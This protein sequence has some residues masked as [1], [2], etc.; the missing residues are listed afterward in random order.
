MSDALT[1]VRD[2]P[3]LESRPQGWDDQRY[4]AHW[5][6]AGPAVRDRFGTVMTF[7]QAA[8]A[9][10]TDPRITRQAGVE[11]LWVQGIRSGP[12]HE[13]FENSVL[14]ANGERHK[15][16]RGPLARA[17]AQPL[18][19]AL[20]GRVAEETEALVR[21]LL[22]RGEADFPA[23][24][25]GP[26]PARMIAAILGAPEADIPHFT[27][28]VYSAS[29]ALS[30]RSPEVL[31]EAAQ[32]LAELERYAAGLLEDRRANPRD[33]FLSEYV[34]RVKDFDLSEA[35]IRWQV[36]TVVIGGSDTTRMALACSFAR[37]LEH[38][39]QWR[40]LVADPDG[41][42][43]GAAAEGLRF[44]PVVG[45]LPRVTTQDCEIA[46]VRLKSGQMVSPSILAA[47]RDPA[48]YAAPERFDIT[49]TDH[50]RLHPV[51]G[52]GAHRCLGEA[53]ARAEL[54]EAL[55]VLARLAPEAE[56]VG[57]APTL[58]GLGGTRGLGPMTVRF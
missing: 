34:A 29:R 40:M 41:M 45:S 37:L 1:E 51:F 35:E 47:L 39:E 42:K 6:Q 24:V 26:L 33:D 11:A 28:L 12:I 23:E 44:D 8:L 5:R 18:M 57:P 36:A 25:C 9:Q 15:P 49:R 20:R 50:P 48:V 10:A 19:N 53:L 27:R 2:L 13:F 21:P 43:A 58:R 54:E 16:R 22:G 14:F 38:P 3:I 31:A 55:A 17:F 32:D 56:L 46:G 52:A 30:F 4:I 7:S